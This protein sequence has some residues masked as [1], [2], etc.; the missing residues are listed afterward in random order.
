MSNQS[1]STKIDT[2][3]LAFQ[4]AADVAR[5]VVKDDAAYKAAARQRGID[6]MTAIGQVFPNPEF[7]LCWGETVALKNRS[8]SWDKWAS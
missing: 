7:I 5:G 6:V 4:K 2:F 8:A 3:S 1:Y